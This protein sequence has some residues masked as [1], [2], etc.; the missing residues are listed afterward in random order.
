VGLRGPNGMRSRLRALHGWEDPPPPPKKRG[1]PPKPALPPT[2]VELRQMAAVARLTNLARG[3][4][5]SVGPGKKGAVS[6]SAPIARMEEI[7]VSL[8]ALIAAA[9][10]ATGGVLSYTDRR[11]LIAPRPRSPRPIKARVEGSGAAT[12]RGVK[13]S[14]A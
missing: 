3:L 11:R 13:T 5:V 4:G 1:R 2:A 8:R 14:C 9:P 10:C 12:A 7:I 6:I